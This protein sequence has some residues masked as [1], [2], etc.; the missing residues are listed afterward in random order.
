MSLLSIF[1]PA[2]VR[3]ADQLRREY[4][5]LDA[6]VVVRTRH[7]PGSKREHV[8]LA[9]SHGEVS[10]W[11]G[12][13]SSYDRR[14]TAKC[15]AQ[16][17]DEWLEEWNTFRDESVTSVR[18]GVAHEL[19]WVGSKR[20]HMVIRNPRRSSRFSDFFEWTRTL[21]KTESP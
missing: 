12:L 17:L 20:R 7:L 15:S 19:A 1:Q 9:C 6:V 16:D 14:I 5:L 21:I 13:A 18:D 8:W 3:E 2:L 11:S 10:V 4:P